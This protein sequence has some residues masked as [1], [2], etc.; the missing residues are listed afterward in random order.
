[1]KDIPR[2]TKLMKK[3]ENK[4]GEKLEE[5]LRRKFVDEGKTIPKIADDL[6]ITY[7]TSV[8][9]LKKAGVY[10]RKLKI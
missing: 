9:W 3:I 10:S 2:K 7:K 6:Q 8:Y 5:V 1:M 4:E